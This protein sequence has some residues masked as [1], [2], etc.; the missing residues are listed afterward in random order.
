MEDLPQMLASMY[1]TQSLMT[2][3][4]LNPCLPQPTE[5]TIAEGCGDPDPA[6]TERAFQWQKWECSVMATG[7]MEGS[8]G[9]W[10][11]YIRERSM[12][13]AGI[14]AFE[15]Y[16]L[17]VSSAREAA[18]QA[19]RM[20]EICP[21]AYAVLGLHAGTLE[22]ALRFYR[23][24]EAQGPALL[25]DFEALCKQGNAWKIAPM[26]GYLRC[27]HGVANT[28]RKIH[29]RKNTPGSTEASGWAAESLQCYQRLA[30]LQK[31]HLPSH[32][33]FINFFA[34]LPEA[35][36]RAGDLKGFDRMWLSNKELGTNMCIYNSSAM[37][38]I[39]SRALRDFLVDPD[40]P[41]WAFCTHYLSVQLG[42]STDESA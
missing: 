1:G 36:L 41:R 26:R 11:E 5:W 40:R 38:W 25:S 10:T 13:S 12:A 24:G 34:Q 2:T 23:A 37:H 6:W 15:A 9:R 4:T 8:I 19:L 32:G 42:R 21:N 31:D 30:E 33:N 35:Y 28:L 18:M 20:H 39:W 16:G 14:K 17:E 27:L 22:E 29:A 7:C 3:Q